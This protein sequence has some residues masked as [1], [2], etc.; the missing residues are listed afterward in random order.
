MRVIAHF[1]PVRKNRKNTQCWEVKPEGWQEG[2]GL[3][4]RTGDGTLWDVCVALHHH[5]AAALISLWLTGHSEVN[6][7][8]GSIHLWRLPLG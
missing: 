1:V 7:D 2:G 8:L 4:W 6:G 5:N 3:A